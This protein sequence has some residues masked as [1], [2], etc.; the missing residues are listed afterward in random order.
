MKIQEKKGWVSLIVPCYN[1]E[2]FIECF[3]KNIAEQTYKKIDLI[4]IDDGSTD[5]TREL[6]MQFRYLIENRGMRCEYYYQ[7]NCGQAAAINTALPKV[8]GEYCSWLDVDDLI[9]KDHIEKKVKKL[10]E[11]E[12]AGAVICKGIAV[13]DKDMTHKLCDL[14]VRGHLGCP[15]ED[16]LFDYMGC[17]PGLYMVRSRLL[18]EALRGRHIYPSRVGQNFQLLLPITYQFK[19]EYIDEILFFYRV[20]SDSHSHCIVSEADWKK[21]IELVE[22][23][24]RN[25]LSQMLLPDAYLQVLLELLKYKILKWK[26]D[27]MIECSEDNSVSKFA[28]DVLAECFMN[29]KDVSRKELWIWGGTENNYKLVKL[30]ELDKKVTVKGFVDSDKEKLKRKIY[31][32]NVISPE[33]L[34]ANTM[35]LLIPL[36]MHKEIG[37]YLDKNG[38]C[39]GK[40]YFYPE[41]QIA[42]RLEEFKNEICQ[43]KRKM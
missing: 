41:Y 16:I 24:K 23:V 22:D 19:L 13:S 30:I 29:L 34:N 42:H 17:E 3:I 43:K 37:V 1:G 9:R 18:F 26:M 36:M 5:N 4:F 31:G 40:N 6:F 15:F 25:V 35:V 2:K 11:N 10:A 38:F 14:S 39:A 32:K 21:R 27:K 12:N 7:E 33:S 20:R 28:S 8:T